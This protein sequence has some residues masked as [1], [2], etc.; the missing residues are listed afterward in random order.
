MIVIPEHVQAHAPWSVSKAGVIKNCSLQFSFRYEQKLPAI[1]EPAA[2][3]NVGTVVHKALEFSLL[4]TPVSQ[5]FDMAVVTTDITSDEEEEVHLFFEQVEDFTRRINLFKK[6]HGVKKHN[7]LIEAKW[8]F[9]YPDLRMMEF[10]SS[11]FMRGAID[12][13]MVTRGGRAVVIDHKSGA[14]LSMDTYEPQLRIYC[15]MVLARYPNIKSVQ[16]GINFTMLN[17]LKF[18]PP[19]SAE[20]IRKEYV[21][22]LLDF[23]TESCQGLLSEPTHAAEKAWFCDYCNYRSACP[24]FSGA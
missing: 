19:V 6:Q 10:F 3:T 7:F 13:C 15:L 5:A 12:L 23:M 21:P 2:A 16:T 4:G 17:D 24:L 22:W 1:D 11:C 20:V 18:N 8:G 14:Q 9:S